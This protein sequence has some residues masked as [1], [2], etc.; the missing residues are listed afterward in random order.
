MLKVSVAVAVAGAVA[1]VA[2]V[3]A[4]ASAQSPVPTVAVTASPTAVALQPA[5]PLAAGPTRFQVS[6]AATRTG[7]SVYFAVLVPGVTFQDLQA[8][9]RRDDRTQGSQSL[10]MVSIVSSVTFSGSETRR[11]VTFTLKPGVSYVMV[12]EPDSQGDNPPASRGFGTFATTTTANGATAPQPAAT[13]RMVDLRF[14]GSAT[15]PRRGVVRFENFG[16]GP[17]IAVAF[18][19]RGSVTSAQF[20][21]AIRSNSDRA[22][23]RLLA[24]EP[25]GLQNVLSGG[26]NANDQTVAFPRAGKYGLVCFVDEHNVLGMY[27]LVTVR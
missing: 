9:L 12:T 17:H 6:R 27:R 15:L 8:A 11:D 24:G 10:G 3:A 4:I 14:T 7:L 22:V 20:G 16:G 23:G 2:V 19:L 21:R 13:V 26:G 1:A 18:P 25:L 5:G